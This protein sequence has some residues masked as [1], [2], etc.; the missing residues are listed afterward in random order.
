MS[1]VVK[2][3]VYWNN[4]LTVELMLKKTEAKTVEW[5]TLLRNSPGD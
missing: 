5:R 3:P 4:L 1:K 2:V